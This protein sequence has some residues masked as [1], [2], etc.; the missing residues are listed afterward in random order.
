M[1]LSK[2]RYLRGLQCPKAPWLFEYRQEPMA[3]P[4]ARRQHLFDTGY[5]VGEP[6]QQHF[7]GAGIPGPA[8]S[9][10]PGTNAWASR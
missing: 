2:S 6:A 9:T 8:C 10:F 5:R 4:D 7:P 3:G 1:H